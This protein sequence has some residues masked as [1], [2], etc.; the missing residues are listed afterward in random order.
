[1][2]K[3][4]KNDALEKQY[5][6]QGEC[7]YYCKQKIPYDLITRDHVKPASKGNL[8]INNKIFAC[9]S[10]NNLKGNRTF[11]EF[12]FLMIKR[13]SDI[14]N[15]IAKKNY[16]LTDYEVKMLDHHVAVINTLNEIIKNNN[17][18]SLVFT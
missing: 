11:E 7:C 9:R 1:M 5:K 14:L 6:E 17:Q 2:I 3:R 10:C 13:C 15:K 8:F 16:K 4:A 18:I 12:R